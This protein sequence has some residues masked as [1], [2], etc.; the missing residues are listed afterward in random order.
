MSTS[1][2]LVLAAAR[3]GER[4]KLL[5]PGVGVFSLARGEGQTLA[6]GDVAGVLTTL[7]STVELLVPDGV[8]G[9]VVSARPERILAP[10]DYGAELYELAPLAAG[11]ARAAQAAAT[12]AA[13]GA[14]VFRSP[15]AGRFWQRSAPGEPVLASVGDLVE[16]GKAIGLIEVMKTFTMVSYA[17]R[18][19]L[20]ARARIARVLVEDGAEVSDKTPLFELESA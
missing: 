19:G 7:G 14:L 6:A 10:A 1:K 16:A 17:T 2:S 18:G 20:P 8:A 9:V 15:S 12:G 13:D 3:E 5:C 4:V 11:S